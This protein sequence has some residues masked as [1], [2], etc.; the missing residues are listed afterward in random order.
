MTWPRADSLDSISWEMPSYK[1]RTALEDEQESMG[2]A[3]Q[4]NYESS[5]SELLA[6]AGFVC[7]QTVVRGVGCEGMAGLRS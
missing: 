4:A 7:P 2:C 6:K 1:E 3:L 5:E